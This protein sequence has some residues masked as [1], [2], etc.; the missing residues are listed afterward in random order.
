MKKLICGRSGM[1]LVELLTVIL[2][3]SVL[4][5]MIG[6]GAAAIGA[7]TEKTSGKAEAGTLLT[8]TAEL[9][10]DELSGALAVRYDE[11]ECLWILSRKE[12]KWIMLKSMPDM[13]ICKVYI[14]A[15][16]EEVRIPLVPLEVMTEGF[17]TD[18]EEITYESGCFTVKNATVV[19]TS[20]GK[21]ETLAILPEL[22][23]RAVNLD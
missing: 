18:L 5:L 20:G 19:R 3:I 7:S 8:V 2:L 11:E 9:L 13:G 14:D 17:C 6:G 1:T 15:D 22:S 4:S 10:T 23:V 16:G 12:E 21:T